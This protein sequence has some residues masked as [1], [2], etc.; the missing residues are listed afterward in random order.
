MLSGTDQDS[1][2]ESAISIWMSG[3]TAGLTKCEIG[4]LEYSRRGNFD[5]PT[6]TCVVSFTEVSDTSRRSISTRTLN[7][8]V[9]AGQLLVHEGAQTFFETCFFWQ[10]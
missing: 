4:S 9:E 5:T 10:K 2:N 3:W 1:W 6:A 8:L 7:M